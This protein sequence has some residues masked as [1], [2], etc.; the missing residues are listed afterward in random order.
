[1]DDYHLSLA[2]QTLLQGS[3]LD[4]GLSGRIH[5]RLSTR[6]HLYHRQGEG[7]SASHKEGR[8][9]EGSESFTHCTDV[10]EGAARETCHHDWYAWIYT[11]IQAQTQT[12]TD[13]Q[14]QRWRQRQVQWHRNT[15]TEMETGTGTEKETETRDRDRD[16][17]ATTHG[18]AGS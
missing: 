4:K 6:K 10:D 7:K 8:G 14:A 11:Q 9:G 5:R 12:Q 2:I 13:T 3:K 1:M 15:G 18:M 16:R 17:P